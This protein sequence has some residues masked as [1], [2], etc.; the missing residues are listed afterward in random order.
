MLWLVASSGFIGAGG[1]WIKC[2]KTS[3]RRS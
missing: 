2:G 3:G 1:G